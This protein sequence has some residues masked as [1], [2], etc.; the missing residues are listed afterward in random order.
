M[1][2][3]YLRNS[4]KPGLTAGFFV[5]FVV[6]WSVDCHVIIDGDDVW[7]VCVIEG[8]IDGWSVIVGPKKFLIIID[9]VRLQIKYILLNTSKHCK[10]STAPLSH[11]ANTNILFLD[12]SGDGFDTPLD[13]Y[14]L[15][16]TESDFVLITSTSFCIAPL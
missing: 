16:D 13:K 8:L 11:P 9:M 2:T 4:Y 15:Y 14:P 12:N 5:G 1:L 7:I 10:S 6:G 3:E